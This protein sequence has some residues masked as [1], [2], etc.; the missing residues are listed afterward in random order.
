MYDK[1]FGAVRKFDIAQIE[2]DYVGIIAERRLV[3]L[4]GAVLRL[5]GNGIGVDFLARDSHKE[6]AH[7]GHKPDP[8]RVHYAR[9]FK[10]GEKFGSLCESFVAHLDERVQKFDEVL[11]FVGKFARRFAHKPYDG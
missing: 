11:I 9:L 6:T 8:A 10:H 7:N 1:K 5:G 2:V 4:R 3:A